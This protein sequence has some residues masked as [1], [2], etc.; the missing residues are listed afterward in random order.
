LFIYLWLC[1]LALFYLALFYLV[2][3]SH[4]ALGWYSGVGSNDSAKCQ[5]MQDRTQP[6]WLRAVFE[7]LLALEGWH[8]WGMR[9]P[10]ATVKGRS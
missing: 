2:Q 8:P 3:L 6:K 5:S 9:T 7:V 4:P 1:Y 10:V